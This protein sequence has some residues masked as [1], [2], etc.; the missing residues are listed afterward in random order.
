M[1][2]LL[3]HKAAR[4][5]AT[6]VGAGVLLSLPVL[7]FGL[8]FLS[9]D[10]ASHAVWYTQYSKQ[11]WEG[12][13]Y[14]RWLMDMNGGLGSPVFYFY[15]P[16]PYYLTSFLRPFFQSDSWGLHQLGLAA[17]AALIGSG[18]AAY[19]WLRKLTS[20]FASM[21]GAI[22]YMAMPYH[23]AS[24][25]YVRASFAEYWTFVWMPLILYF[26][27]R[28]ASGNRL[29]L[30]WLSIA[31]ALLMMTHLPTTLMFGPVLFCYALVIAPTN[32]KLKTL[33]FTTFAALL[34]TALAAIYLV[35]AMMTQ[36]LV[37]I[38]RMT[39]GYFSY[40]NW[41][42]FAKFSLWREDKV[43]MLLLVADMIALASCAFFLNRAS[44]DAQ[45][46]KINRFWFTV[47]LASLLMMTQ[48][49]KPVWLALS[50]LQ[51]IQFPW[52]FNCILAL[53]TTALLSISIATLKQRSAPWIAKM[54]VLILIMVWVPVT[55]WKVSKAFPQTNHDQEVIKSKRKE[56]EQ[57]RDAPE[58]RPRWSESMARLDWNASLD[59]DHWD[60]LLEKETDSLL[61]VTSD[62]EGVA[63][64]PNIVE[65]VGNARILSRMPRQIG[66]HVESLYGMK[67]VV[68]QFYYPYWTA[69]LDGETT[70]LDLIP[71]QPN[72]F[73][74]LT[75]PGGSHD[76]VLRLERSRPEIIGALI[77][78][79]SLVI[80]SGLGGFF[81]W[82]EYLRARQERGMEG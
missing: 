2:N 19:L 57:S 66:L 63:P 5:V 25:L 51:K 73:I 4:Q 20:D 67:L 24:D 61:Q 18:L 49:S 32:E 62:A 50:V 1:T 54:I 43:T 47:A 76:V 33:S 36:N 39:T 16:T 9:D 22:L 82:S 79:T 28:L 10:A 27:H 38:S 58:Y 56:I 17:S 45:T 74:S 7:I 72:G 55:V 14:P 64:G 48:L 69:H 40:A 6:I 3:K 26:V 30:I 44:G 60:S 78:L 35:P 77:S 68:P 29:P 53:S 75:V 13:L 80:S 52:R 37:L 23:L 8:P 41:L 70:T 31:L 65:G 34:G 12:D 21:L 15:P 71:S 81:W 42:F 46:R 11:L 59:I